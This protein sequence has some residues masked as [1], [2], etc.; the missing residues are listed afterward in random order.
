[1]DHD[2]TITYSSCTLKQVNVLRKLKCTICKQTLSTNSCKIKNKHIW[3]GWGH[4][5]NKSSTSTREQAVSL[6]LL[7]FYFTHMRQSLYKNS[8]NMFVFYLAAICIPIQS[9]QSNQTR[10]TTLR[11]FKCC[12]LYPSPYWSF[13]LL[14]WGRV[15]TRTYQE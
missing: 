10:S 8:S 14:I 1:M 12:K 6:S 11:T 7:I 4:I 13:I 15:Y 5:F 9:H 2:F 3:W